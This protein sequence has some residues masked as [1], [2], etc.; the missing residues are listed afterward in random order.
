MKQLQEMTQAEASAIID[1]QPMYGFSTQQAA[2][3]VTLVKMFIDPMQ[4]SC[5]ACGSS[6]RIAKDKIIKYYR[7]NKTA[8][9]AIADGTYVV[10]EEPVL[11]TEVE[12]RVIVEE[13]P[14][15]PIVTIKKK[16]KKK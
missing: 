15:E 16:N 12:Q 7:E 1:Y 8:I 2:H 9:D 5:A 6:L 13:A 3:L 4:Q 10:L 11:L 14:A